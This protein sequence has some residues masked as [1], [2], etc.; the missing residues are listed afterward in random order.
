MAILLVACGGGGP[1]PTAEP[2]ITEQA[3]EPTAT[4]IEPTPTQVPVVDPDQILDELWVLVGYGDALDPTVVERD[5]LVTM[6]LSRD[7]KV[8]GSWGCNNYS[9]TYE[10]QPD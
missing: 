4:T 7:G 8:S 5:T 9:S 3:L 6:V 10:F 1:E 2:V